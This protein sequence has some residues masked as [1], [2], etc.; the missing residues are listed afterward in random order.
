MIRLLYQL[1]D[2]MPE[3]TC[4]DLG[5][6]WQPISDDEEEAIE[7]IQAYNEEMTAILGGAITDLEEKADKMD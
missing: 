1:R 6:A 5:I 3:M 7:R 2:D 4:V